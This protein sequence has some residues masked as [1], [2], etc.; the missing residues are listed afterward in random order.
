M[1]KF[2]LIYFL[3]PL[4]INAK[5]V[6]S[7]E[8]SIESSI[9]FNNPIVG[10][11]N[12]INKLY[13]IDKNNVIQNNG[14][15]TIIESNNLIFIMNLENGYNY[16]DKNNYK[17]LLKV[18]WDNESDD[19]F[20]YEVKKYYYSNNPTSIKLISG[21]SKK[22]TVDKYCYNLSYVIKTVVNS[23]TFNKDGEN[24]TLFTTQERN[25]LFNC[26]SINDNYYIVLDSVNKKSFFKSIYNKLEN[27]NLEQ[28]NKDSYLLLKIEKE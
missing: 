2:N 15:T 3:F 24:L 12:Y 13:I 7:V 19:F 18:D 5:S 22:T 6:N 8:S 20:N 17:Y 25:G 4:L 16:L 28:N 9:S 11:Y 23:Q 1:K 26:I 21:V 14:I 27:F 10:G